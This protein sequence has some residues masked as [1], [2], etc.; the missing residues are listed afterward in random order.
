MS[1]IQKRR[2]RKLQELVEGKIKGAGSFLVEVS[3]GS[4]PTIVGMGMRKGAPYLF[5]PWGSLFYS[6]QW[7]AILFNIQGDR[8]R[9]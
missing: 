9:H 8:A 6:L 5:K 1:D 7:R 3:R 2:D 4:E